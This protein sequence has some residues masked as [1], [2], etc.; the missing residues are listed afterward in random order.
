VSSSCSRVAVYFADN[1][2]TA[3]ST[4]ALQSGNLQP[5]SAA[6]WTTGEAVNAQN[7]K[8]STCIS[9]FTF[10]F[11]TGIL[12]PR[13]ISCCHLLAPSS[14]PQLRRTVHLL[15]GPA[16]HSFTL[17]RL[18]KSELRTSRQGPTS[19]IPTTTLTNTTRSPLLL[20]V[21]VAHIR[22]RNLYS[23]EQ[24]SDHNG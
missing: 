24:H 3:P 15:L 19:I 8:K 14:K 9:P 10:F 5:M 17:P 12:H 18:P 13:S 7:S 2:N 6:T 22:L 20:R 4:L 23:A 21:L 1:S 11:H 16:F